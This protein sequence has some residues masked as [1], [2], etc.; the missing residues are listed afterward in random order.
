[1][2]ALDS[3][4]RQ[5]TVAVLDACWL[6]QKLLASNIANHDSAGFQARSVD[7]SGFLH[8]LGNAIESKKA[9]ES[10]SL[11]TWP[12]PRI[13]TVDGEVQLDT[14]LSELAVNAARYEALLTALGRL[15]SLNR[16]AVDGGAR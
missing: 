3:I 6:Q 4:T 7:F 8:R 2:E 15:Q 5:T 16:M 1:M 9:A 12:Q 13:E 14:Q 11:S 10:S